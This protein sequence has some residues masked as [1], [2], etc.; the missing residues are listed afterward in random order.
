MVFRVGIAVA[1]SL[2]PAVCGAY[3]LVH[4]VRWSAAGAVYTG[5]SFLRVFRVLLNINKDDGRCTQAQFDCVAI[6]VLV[7]TEVCSP[8]ICASP[9]LLYQAMVDQLLPR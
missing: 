4:G 6:G 7:L 8:T 9:S 5:A 2:L 3:P 1:V